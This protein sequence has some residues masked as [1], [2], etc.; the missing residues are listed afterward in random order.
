MLSACYVCGTTKDIRPYGPHGSMICFSCMKASP[1]REAEAKLQFG[2]QL[3][4]CGDVAVIDDTG[5][6]PY[7][8]E[9]ANFPEAS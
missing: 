7:T 2:A 8:L 5:A 3:A 6:G 9:H 1:K 4:A